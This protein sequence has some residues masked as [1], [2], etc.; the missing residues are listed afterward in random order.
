MRT[1]NHQSNS[2]IHESTTQV[3]LNKNVITEASVYTEAA[4]SARANDKAS[5]DLV[6]AM[7][8]QDATQFDEFKQIDT[9]N[10][11]K[12]V[13]FNDV[14]HIKPRSLHGS[15]KPERSLALN[16]MVSSHR[17][18]DVQLAL[19]MEQPPLVEGNTKVPQQV[20]YNL[21]YNEQVL[22]KELINITSGVVNCDTH[23][24]SNNNSKKAN[25]H[26]IE[27]PNGMDISLWF[28]TISE[29]RSLD[30]VS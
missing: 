22:N 10:T 25:I 29:A 21:G 24:D 3:E 19:L 23:S 6:L 16:N 17:F 26:S 14:Y 7:A 18:K 13:L 12:D 4:R 28:N 15:A 20:F 9:P 8:T 27:R 5:F 2:A 30:L 11:F 1:N